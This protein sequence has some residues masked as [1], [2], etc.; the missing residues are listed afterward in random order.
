M[1]PITI[2]ATLD[3]GAPR[4]AFAVSV[5]NHSADHRLR[6]LFPTAAAAVDTA[7]ADT[8]FDVITRPARIPVPD[9]IRNESPVSTMPMIS[10]VDAGDAVA[11]ATVIGKGLME[12]EIV[13]AETTHNAEHADKSTSGSATSASAALL[14][15][16]DATIAV[17]LIRAVGD[18]SRNDL[19]TRPSG[20]AGPPVATPAAQCIGR[21][22][23]EL[24][25]E[26]RAAAPTAGELMASARA[27]NIPPVVRIARVGAGAAPLTRAFLRLE[28]HS[29]DVTLSALKQAEDRASTIVRLFNPGEGEADVTVRIDQQ[30]ASAFAVNL[31]EERQAALPIDDRGIRLRFTPKQIQTIEIISDASTRRPGAQS[32]SR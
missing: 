25:F 19:A 27:H 12:Y 23:F 11:G 13:G 4:L 28:R 1:T 29:G 20:H 17:T 14:T 15:V 31:L 22:K 7:R 5:D 24:A 10:L 3:A 8:A 2:D 18:L 9:T 26:P 30:I 16:P 21:Q 6:M 32:P